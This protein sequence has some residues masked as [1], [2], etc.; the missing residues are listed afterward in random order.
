MARRVTKFKA[1]N[2][3]GETRKQEEER[4]ARVARA[5]FNKT[6]NPSAHLKLPHTTGAT[7][8]QLARRRKTLRGHGLPL[9]P[10]L[11]IRQRRAF[12]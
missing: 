8:S 10:T 7:R 3:L 9:K 12:L 2:L 5:S 4:Y 11:T 1:K 6:N